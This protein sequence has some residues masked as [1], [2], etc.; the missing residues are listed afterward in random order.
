MDEAEL[1]L[2]RPYDR[3][4]RSTDRDFALG[5]CATALTGWNGL[6]CGLALIM[7]RAVDQRSI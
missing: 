5:R 4:R 3:P 6:A 1:R 7:L 2:A